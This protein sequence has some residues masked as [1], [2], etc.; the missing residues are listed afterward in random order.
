MDRE[1]HYTY[2][3]ER[4]LTAAARKAGMTVAKLL[5]ANI[6]ER[7]PQLVGTPFY[8]AAHRAMRE[9]TAAELET[10][11]PVTGRWMEARL[12]PSYA[13]LSIYL[14][15]ISAR[16]RADEELRESRRRSETILES[17]T[18]DFVAVDHDWR[19][20]YLN[21]RALR[22]T[23]EWLGRPISREELLGRSLWDV[24]PEIVG[25]EP[26]V[27]YHEAVRDGRS[28]QFETYFAAKDRWFETHAYP[29]ESGLS[30]YF[31]DVS[32]RKRMEHERQRRAREQVLIAEL[33]LRA[34][35]S[36]DLQ[37]L[38][39]EA[40]E[41][42][43]RTLDVALAM[44]AEMPPGSDEAIFRA[45]VG[46]R[47]GVVG[48]VIERG[49]DSQAGYTLLRGEPVIAED[50]SNDPR[51]KRSALADEYGVVS[52][53]TVMIA[54]P[55]EPF[56]VLEALSTRRRAFSESD[57]SFVQAVAN[58][59]AGAVERR[60]ANERLAEVREAERRRIAREL[61]DQAL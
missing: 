26:Y 7:F 36:D 2:V 1:W 23:Q 43:G 13:G 47:E 55:A 10:R 54:S 44:V 16:K 42:V 4:S 28:V 34:L 32:E 59:L 35:A 3:N 40:V 27:K 21:D 8:D 46:W 58:V 15:D 56:G 9:Q 17:I 18:D 33:G 61:H 22:S 50:Q 53:L 49:H 19:Y 30:V 24:F 37:A 57:V 51:F 60:R 6:W 11:S 45:G 29:S 31:R 25:A 20:I 39:D 38:M 48:R 5:G 14:H 52:A 12:Y 41:L